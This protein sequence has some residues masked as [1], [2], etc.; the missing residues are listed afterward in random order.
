M[1]TLGALFSSLV[2]AGCASR[3]A[4]DPSAYDR[5]GELGLITYYDRNRDGFVD[6]ELHDFGCCDANWAL[7]DSHFRG[8]Y[9]LKVQ[10]AYSLV[11][12]PVDIPV[13]S[14]VAISDGEPD[15]PESW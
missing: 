8:R 13:A 3:E 12:T 6:Y 10:W 5:A 9:D 14:G 1:R 7:V 4:Y 2:L 11:E 15:V